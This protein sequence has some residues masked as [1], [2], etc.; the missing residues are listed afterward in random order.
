MKYKLKFPWASSYDG[1]RQRCLNPKSINYSNYGGRGI[2]FLLTRKECHDLWV[3]DEGDFMNRP[4]LDRID[5]NGDYEYKNCQ[6]MELSENIRKDKSFTPVVRISENGD[7]KLYESMREASRDV[8][9]HASN[10]WAV[11]NGKKPTCRGYKWEYVTR[12]KG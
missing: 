2:K 12:K 3:R 8:E 1:S 7:R 10:I 11:V 5:S 9:G 4:S 6:F